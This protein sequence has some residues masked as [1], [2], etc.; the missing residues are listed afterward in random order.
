M[1]Q[2]FTCSQLHRRAERIAGFT[3]EKAKLNSGDNVALLF[4]AGTY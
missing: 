3:L 4:P 2:K 1:S